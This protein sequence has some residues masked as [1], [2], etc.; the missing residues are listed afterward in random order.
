M[1]SWIP[2]LRVARREARRSK[3]RSLLVIALIGLPVLLL[4][5]FVAT[6]D[7]H[8]LTPAERLD[9]TIGQAD[10]RIA[11][12][13]DGPLEQDPV[14]EGWSAVDGRLTRAATAEDLLA[15][16]PPG[17]R[18]TRV[19][20]GPVDMHAPY[21]IGTTNGHSM[22]LAD[23][24]VR[25]IVNLVSGTLPQRDDE[26]AI[27]DAVADWLKVGIGDTVRTVSPERTFTVTAFVEFP[28]SL[29]GNIV[30]R[31]GQV[32][33]DGQW[34][35]DSP[36]PLTWPDVQN[37]N[38]H[39]IVAL[40]RAVVLDPPPV[41]WA[42]GRDEG[43]QV[44]EI[45]LSVVVVGLI[46]LEVVLLAGPAFAVGARRRS[47]DLALVAAAGGTP[48]QLRRIVLADGVVLGAIAAVGGV[49]G[50]MLLA[51]LLRPVVEQ[52]LIGARAGGL[53]FYLPA[54][55]A[56]IALSIGTGL[57]AALVPAFTAARQDVV[58][59][60]AGRR[61]I[62]RSR[63]R[64]IVFG[65]VMAAAGAA[66]AM[67]GAAA[68]RS[69]SVV[70]TGVIVGEL[71][72]VLLTPAL[73]G[74]I[75]R[76]GRLLPLAPR[77]ALRD[78]AR[79]RGSAAPAISAVMAAVAGAV[80]IGAFVGSE[81]Q[82]SI[83]NYRPVLPVGNFGVRYVGGET[84]TPPDWAKVHDAVQRIVPQARLQPYQGVTC[85]W[86]TAPQ[87]A[88]PAAGPTPAPASPAPTGT[89]VPTPP[90]DTTD[91]VNEVDRCTIDMFIPPVNQCPYWQYQPDGAEP[92]WD[93][94]RADAR[95]NDQGYN[96]LQF[97][98]VDDGDT[99][100]ALTDA[101]PEAISAAKRTLAAGGVV[102]TNPL[103]L[104]DGKVE[105]TPLNGRIVGD[106]EDEPKVG[107]P[108]T[109]LA[110]VAGFTLMVPPALAEE[111]GFGL[112]QDGIV[113]DGHTPDANESQA[114]E[115]ALHDL[116]AAETTNLFIETGAQ[117]RPEPIIWIL[118]VIA[119]LIALGAAGV[120]TGLAGA[121][122]RADLVTLAAVGASP[123][124]R[125]R[126]SLSQSGVISGLGALLGVLAGLGTAYALIL[127]LNTTSAYGGSFPLR[128]VL[129]WSSLAI[130]AAVPLIAMAG[131]GLLTR[132][133]LPVERRL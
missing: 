96:V 83:D 81:Q 26:V 11:K 63:K 22:D 61:G 2:A 114:L 105:L 91:P 108:G 84:G 113:G 3:G 109:Y 51:A 132:S 36:S 57:L 112:R 58:A 23:P 107:V 33:T 88:Q 122:S 97:M 30:F 124:V 125:R 31:P 42:Y 85:A 111:L 44:E 15:A 93:A 120:A 74:L 94:I 71:G 69:S 53:R 110:G 92:D 67:L 87:P 65:L 130:V 131:A 1:K 68:G 10:A 128:L 28:D 116:A 56:I 72:L 117:Y 60:L 24:M 55:A 123:G 66:T 48:K 121:E 27:N 13:V 43:P 6:Y 20:G 54:Q 70:L 127:A 89:P 45:A 40:S 37:L 21:G 82:Y 39:G 104:V 18:L 95:C 35:A 133:R 4:S 46:V 76:L 126:L 50:G 7:M 98:I 49:L 119:A 17:S 73:V 75:S 99:L 106:M 101:G 5:F 19:G 79:N 118:G 64:W 9:R 25:G 103:Y 38:R 86:Q 80:S 59:V 32:F 78:T 77:I 29:H 100:G 52:Y 34:L 47:R 16:L 102:V 12:Y 115:G 90:V 62:T 41:Q 129:P 14:S 8:E